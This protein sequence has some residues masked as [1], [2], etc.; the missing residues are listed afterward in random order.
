VDSGV[1]E[2]DEI[3]TYYD[4]MIAKLVSRGE[5]RPAAA[6]QLA[7]ACRQV[8]IWPIKTNAAFLARLTADPDYVAGNVDTDF[9]A[10]NLAR[11]LPPSEPDDAVVE[12]AA[13]ALVSSKETGPWTKLPGFRMGSTQTATV[14]VT[15]GN[16]TRVISFDPLVTKT[17]CSI[18]V[19]QSGESVLFRDGRGWL[20]HRPRAKRAEDVNGATDGAI[21]APMPGHVVAVE[22]ETG[23]TVRKGQRLFVLEAMKM[24]QSLFA[25]FDGVVT[26]LRVRAGARV[27]EG[28]MLGRVRNDPP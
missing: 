28:T 15:I 12:A 23:T 16:R 13:L 24:E 4:P 25:P 17:P 1:D 7:D 8:E 26:D 18:A 2:G 14:A 19:L 20:F 11:V 22:V 10:R 3:S 21:L 5:T 6:R 27:S 9:I